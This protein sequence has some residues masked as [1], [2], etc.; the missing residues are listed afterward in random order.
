MPQ[1]PP[2]PMDAHGKAGQADKNES[3]SARD[4]KDPA[5]RHPGKYPQLR[6]GSVGT[7][8]AAVRAARSP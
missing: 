4:T 1:S 6:S 5:N 2:S 7:A 8:R 3:Q